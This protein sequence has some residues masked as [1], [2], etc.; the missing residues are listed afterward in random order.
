M[1]RCILAIVSESLIRDADTQNSSII[2]IAEAWTV[3]EFPTVV[4]KCAAFFI[5]ERD[6][7]DPDTIP[8][9]FE[10]TVDGTRIGQG[11]GPVEFGNGV[12]TRIAMEIQGLVV[13]KPGRLKFKISRDGTELG[14]WEVIVIAPAGEPKFVPKSVPETTIEQRDVTTDE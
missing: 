7:D 2:N 9:E 1:I 12:R 6:K 13:P 5:L 4:V 8:I 3:R 11:G 10:I 14:A